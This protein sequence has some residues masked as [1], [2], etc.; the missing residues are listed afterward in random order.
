VKT[1][2]SKLL[3]DAVRLDS[4]AYRNMVNEK[5]KLSIIVVG[6]C[7]V[8]S[9][10]LS[11]NNWSVVMWLQLNAEEDSAVVTC[12]SERFAVPDSLMH[13]FVIVPSKL[14]L[15]TLAAFLMWKCRVSLGG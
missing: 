11:A 1:E 6:K 9:A 13:H 7:C 5:P 2:S 12:S 10:T 4:K 15:V 14:R 3:Q 8:L